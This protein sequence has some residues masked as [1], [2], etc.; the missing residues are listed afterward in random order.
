MTVQ[1]GAQRLLRDPGMIRQKKWGLVT[2]YTAVLPNLELTATALHRETGAIA[3]IFG[4]EHG[5]RGTAQAGFAEKE[6]TDPVTGLPLVDTYGLDEDA[7]DQ[8]IRELGI[9]AM[10]ADIQDVG[11]R[12]YTYAWTVVDCMRSAARLGIPF[13]VLDRPNP[14]SG[15]VREGPGVVPADRSF[16]GRLDIPIRHGLTLGELVREASARDAAAGLV[17][18]P[19]QVVLMSGWERK[20]YW[21]D[22]GLPW[23]MPSPNLPTPDSALVYVGTALFEGTN[24]SEGRGTTRPF[25]LVG[26][27]WLDEEYAK[28]LQVRALPGVSFRSDWFVPTFQKHAGEPVGGVQ[29][30]V[31]DRDEFNPVLTAVTMLEVAKDLG[32]DQFEWRMPDWESDQDARPFIDLLWGSDT[33]RRNLGESRTPTELLEA[34]PQPG[35]Y[36]TEMLY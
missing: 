7:L 36:L 4:P 30:H 18:E 19:P 17:A 15:A 3:A 13:Y 33:L 20:M 14:L 34:S 1:T 6:T 12:F 24:M 32:G 35:I 10:V 5:L 8:A 26:A 31:T 29:L 23:V 2:N 25:E 27:P 9:D 22:T 11:A 16:V 28:S 21:D